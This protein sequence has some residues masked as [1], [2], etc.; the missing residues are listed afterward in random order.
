MPVYR[1]VLAEQTTGALPPPP[2]AW[3]RDIEAD[4]GFDAVRLAHV[5]YQ[6]ELG[7]PCASCFGRVT[8]LERDAPTTTRR[9]APAAPIARTRTAGKRPDGSTP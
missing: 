9:A 2:V 3:S 5:A 4:N 1:V 8:E 7:Y 6:A